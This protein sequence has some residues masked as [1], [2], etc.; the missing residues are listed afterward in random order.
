M[1][2][3]GD[4]EPTGP[5]IDSENQ[6]E[7]I[8]ARRAR[9]QGRQE[10]LKR[11][12]LGE[13]EDQ[14]VVEHVQ[15]VS[16]RQMEDSYTLLRKLHE[17]GFEMVTNIRVAGDAREVARRIEEEEARR[18]RKEKL[19]AEFKA[20][21]ERFEEI[22]KKWEFALQKEIP[23]D[24]H[25]M[26]TQQK[27][28]CDS[29]LDEKNKLITD[30][31]AELKAKDDQYVRDLKKQAED[32]DLLIERMESQVKE[33]T[34]SY[35]SELEEIEKSFVL[36]RTEMLEM[37]AKKWEQ[38]LK[39][40]RQKE[41]EYMELREKRVEE[42]EQQLQQLRI[43]D[44]EEYNQVKIKLETD[45]QILQQQLQQM[46][47]TYQLNQEKLEYNFQV[48]RKRDE[49]NTITKSQQKRKITKLHDVLTNLKR[50]L[51]KQE[52]SYKDDNQQLTTD[53][54][55]QLDQFR[56]VQRKAKTFMGADAKKF[57][58]IWRM[59]EEEAK[60]LTR[61]ALE[62]DRIIHEQQLGLAWSPPA[63]LTF[64]N[65][66]GPVVSQKT[67]L[68]KGGTAKKM[69]H[70]VLNTTDAQRSKQSNVAPEEGQLDL[71]A[72]SV[73]LYVPPTDA[74]LQQASQS[75]VVSDV[76]SAEPSAAV[77]AQD[78][79]AE[80]SLMT[81]ISQFSPELIKQILELLCDE[82]GFL[83]ES[84]LLTLL[85]PLQPC[86]QTLMKLDAIFTAMG[87]ESEEDVQLLSRYFLKFRAP[88]E[89]V[90][91]QQHA[92]DDAELTSGRNS[93]MRDAVST[94]RG[95]P[96]PTRSV[97]RPQTPSTGYMPS[98]NPTMTGY[99]YSTSATA[100]DRAA[101]SHSAHGGVGSHAPSTGS[102]NQHTGDAYSSSVTAV[103][104]AATPQSTRG[105]VS[106]RASSK[107]SSAAQ[108]PSGVAEA[109]SSAKQA[110]LSVAESGQTELINANDVLKAL[111]A[112]VEESNKHRSLEKSQMADQ[113]TIVNVNDRD[114]SDDAAYWKQYKYVISKD[115]EKVWDALLGSFEKYYEVLNA[116]GKLIE[117]TDGLRQQNGELRLLLH[118]YVNSKVNQE[119]QV[120]PTS[121]YQFNRIL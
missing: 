7:R 12:Q 76:T 42:F 47:A 96:S 86:E 67:K 73:S 26:L 54:R 77:I 14:K 99:A 107:A 106:S 20:G 78:S 23:Q 81:V 44:A 104:R 98:L 88:E 62:A 94:D 37:Q 117:E 85:A 112:F 22:T 95:A 101:S 119:L 15:T 57:Q 51:E 70:Q 83:I 17:D 34:K 115:T 91:S 13:D 35:R 114:A 6:Q 84:K 116:R 72:S 24:L 61:K 2:N 53:Y 66:V 4:D 103:D 21:A 121:V 16:Q 118:Q 79:K 5:S 30:Y 52:K 82:S 25:E 31:Q 113:F 87:I 43:Q 93:R 120:P 19:E 1:D 50:K 46:K 38:M 55:H 75:T 58:E 89:Q 49:E 29:M 8:L 108:M 3:Q 109:G 27:T 36:E 18:Q 90:I 60:E 41:I 28:A 65:N 74:E 105:G 10:K 63:D 110:A 111:R 39:E 71:W 64:M 97:S 56:D 9:I 59:N 40:R 68:K 69:A 102:L 92:G 48:L 32:I 45:V 80:T 33:L 11:A 100:V